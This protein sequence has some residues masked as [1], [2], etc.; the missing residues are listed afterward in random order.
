MFLKDNHYQW[1]EFYTEIVNDAGMRTKQYWVYRGIK[2]QVI[3]GKETVE[4][5]VARGVKIQAL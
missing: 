4:Q 5:A 2:D 1:L 3:P